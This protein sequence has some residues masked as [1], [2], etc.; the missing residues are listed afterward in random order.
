MPVFFRKK[1]LI[2]QKR[3]YWVCNGGGKMPRINKLWIALEL[4][5]LI[6]FNALFFII[7]GVD[8]KISVWISYGFI[9]I[10]YAMVA[11]TPVFTNKTKSNMVLGMSLYSV[12]LVYFIVEF[13]IG[14]LFILISLNGW[15]TTFLVQL[16]LVG[17]YA[18]AFISSLIANEHTATNE[19]R[20][21]AE[22]EYVKS[23]SAKLASIMNSVTDK[24]AKRAIEAAYDEIAASPAKSHPNLLQYEGTILSEV[25]IL[26]ELVE[27]DDNPAIAQQANKTLSMIKERNRQLKVL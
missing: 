21:S 15:K 7:G 4:I 24:N 19:M 9:H 2:P 20:S 8:H 11:L 1:N 14:L 26:S 13:V 16:V 25:G 18:T 10:A 6:V 23:M 27:E 5:F 22:I 12:S 17:I 3:N